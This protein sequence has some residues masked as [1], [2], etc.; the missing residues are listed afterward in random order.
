ML[1]LPLAATQACQGLVTG[2]SQLVTTVCRGPAAAAGTNAADEGSEE[3]ASGAPTRRAASAAAAASGVPVSGATAAAADGA[4]ASH[5]HVYALHK[6]APMETSMATTARHGGAAATNMAACV[7]RFGHD[8][9][10]MHVGRLDKHT[11]GLLLFTNSGALANSIN[12]PGRTRKVYRVGFDVSM[13]P[14]AGAGRGARPA[15]AAALFTPEQRAVCAL[16]ACACRCAWVRNGVHGGV[17]A[18]A[19]LRAW[20]C[21]GSPRFAS[22]P[23]RVASRCVC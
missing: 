19:E 13:L 6:P 17:R 10:L 20:G 16:C 7:E 2:L 21:L 3:R 9:A 22:C 12:L 4:A 11:T 1:A 15:A 5:V 8:G 23:P 18:W 14:G